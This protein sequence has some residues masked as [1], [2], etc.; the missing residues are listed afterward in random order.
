MYTTIKLDE[1]N[2]QSIPSNATDASAMST[3]TMNTEATNDH[4][5]TSNATAMSAM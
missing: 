4:S 1:I 3:A 2:H 5:L